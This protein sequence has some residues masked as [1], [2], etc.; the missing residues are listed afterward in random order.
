MAWYAK[1]GILTK[2]TVFGLNGNQ[3]M[4]GGEAGREAVLPLN[5]STLGEIGRSI[6]ETM[7]SQPITVSITISDIVVREEADVVYLAEEVARRLTQVLEREKGLKGGY[8]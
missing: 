5:R 2:P 3:L 1:G 7:V 4:A 8:T 6:A